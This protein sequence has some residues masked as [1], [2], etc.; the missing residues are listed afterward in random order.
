MYQSERKMEES[1]SAALDVHKQ[2]EAGG[3]DGD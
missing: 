3:G 2:P 1:P